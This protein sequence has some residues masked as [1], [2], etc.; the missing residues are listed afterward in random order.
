MR[1]YGASPGTPKSLGFGQSRI[2]TELRTPTDSDGKGTKWAER[3]DTVE[4]HETAERHDTAERQDILLTLKPEV[5]RFLRITDTGVCVL[6]L[7]FI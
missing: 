7:F 6:T 5:T 4:R 3:H 2:R 1:L